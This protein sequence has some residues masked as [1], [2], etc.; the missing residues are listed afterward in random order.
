MFV[1]SFVRQLCCFL[2]GFDIDVDWT[3]LFLLPFKETF[4]KFDEVF[5]LGKPAA[6]NLGYSLI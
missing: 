2:L 6:W 3:G 1:I 5:D 4:K